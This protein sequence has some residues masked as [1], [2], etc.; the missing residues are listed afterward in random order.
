MNA[1]LQCLA[2]TGPLRE[3]LLDDNFRSDINRNNNLGTGGE[4]AKELSKL[5]TKMWTTMDAD[6][7]STLPLKSVLDNHT[8]Q[9]PEGIQQDTH[10]FA[11]SILDM[12]HE[13]T[14]PN[15]GNPSRIHQLTLGQIESTVKCPTTDDISTTIDKSMFLFTPIPQ[16]AEGEEARVTLEDCIRKNFEREE[17]VGSNMWNCPRCKKKVPAWIESKLGAAPPI[18][19]VPIK[20][21]HYLDNGE[22]AYKIETMVDFPL[23][24][25]NLGELMNHREG[26][27]I[28]PVYDC[29]AVA[30]HFGEI[31][32]GHY[33][34]YCKEDDGTWSNYDDG[35]VTPDVDEKKV[36]ACD[37]YCL[38]YK[39]RD[40]DTE[41][42][43]NDGGGD[44][45]EESD[46]EEN[47]TSTS[48][49]GSEDEDDANDENARLSDYE[50]L[51]LANIKRNEARLARLGL[52]TDEGKSLLG[53]S[54]SNNGNRKKPARQVGRTWVGLF[55][56][57]IVFTT[58][59]VPPHRRRRRRRRSRALPSS[60]ESGCT[61]P[62]KAIRMTQHRGEIAQPRT[63]RK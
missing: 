36:V 49:E 11:V 13:D 57:C 30:N 7:T 26:N 20:R 4:L 40:A 15:N 2:H 29:Y 42:G 41:L 35:R 43:G 59:F 50:R 45:D 8:G 25:L 56:D 61:E 9:F 38:Y 31:A 46:D 34:A 58:A 18:M 3:Y 5:I 32:S 27:G 17:L 24:G 62:V 22:P 21:F 47:Y 28:E 16:L 44:D 10:E 6:P 37:A 33:T 52:L 54:A 1:T 14:K 39:R 63:R 23:R 53:S 55:L 19:I 60:R 51:R 12:V 48:E